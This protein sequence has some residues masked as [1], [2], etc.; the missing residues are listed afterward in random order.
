[1]GVNPERL[2]LFL[3]QVCVPLLVPELLS[4]IVQVLKTVDFDGE[5][6]GAAEQ[7]DFVGRAGRAAD[8][9]VTVEGVL[10]VGMATEEEVS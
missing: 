2:Y 7:I 1:M 5:L 10:H 9:Y 3:G 6:L 8:A 4:G